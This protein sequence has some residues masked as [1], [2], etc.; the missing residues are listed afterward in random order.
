MDTNFNEP[1][2]TAEVLSRAHTHNPDL[3]EFFCSHELCDYC[4]NRATDFYAWYYYDEGPFDMFICQSC[5]ATVKK[6]GE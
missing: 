4:D 6:G 5:L 2:P 1:L 3:I